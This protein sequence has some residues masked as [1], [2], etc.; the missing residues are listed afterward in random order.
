MKKSYLIHVQNLPSSFVAWINAIQSTGGRVEIVVQEGLINHVAVF[1]PCKTDLSDVPDNF[2]W[3]RISLS[4]TYS[5]TQ[6]T[7]KPVIIGDKFYEDESNVKQ[8]IF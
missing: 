6:T 4:N 2:S 8:E 5:F 1:Y 3:G 7:Y